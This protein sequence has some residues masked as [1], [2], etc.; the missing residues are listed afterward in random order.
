MKLR[1]LIAIGL[2]L[3]YAQVGAAQQSATTQP[4][5]A[6]P[7]ASTKSV[8][9]APATQTHANPQTLAANT[10]QQTITTTQTASSTA[11]TP[12]TTQLIPN[13]VADKQRVSYS[14]GVDLGQNFKNQGI[15][16]DPTMLERGLKD[17][18]TGS[19]TMYTTQDMATALIDFQKQL[20]AKRQV[21]FAEVSAKNQQE[22]QA[23][24]ATNKNKP[25]V[26]TTA[27]G[28]QYKIIAPG[29]G[30]SPTA[31]DVVTVDYVG[32]F[33]NGKVFDSS[34]QRGKP[35]TFHVAEVIPGWTEIL[36]QMKPGATY[37][38][39]VPSNLAYGERGLA[40]VIQPNQ[41]LI[42]KIHLIDVKAGN[43]ATNA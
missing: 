25:G 14:I 42:F 17:A 19:K 4:I 37:E 23:F 10:S 27:S 18:L 41:T 7:S 29:T 13:N 31:S 12:G 32:T 35:V 26:V 21:Q 11:T 40:N 28:L 20:V 30:P 3:L 38:I 34:Y 6:G 9:A 15:D 5:T 22:G 36:K 43:G 24:L 2:G 8:A 1:P 39:Y 16:V 33:L